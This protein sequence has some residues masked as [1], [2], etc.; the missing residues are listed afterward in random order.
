MSAPA[1]FRERS[2][3]AWLPGRADAGALGFCL[4]CAGPAILLLFP[5]ALP[6]LVPYAA[7]AALAVVFAIR[8]LQTGELVPRTFVDWPILLSLLVLPLG[9]WATA[10]RSV[11][12]PVIFRMVAGVAIFYGVAALGRTRWVHLLPWSAL[13]FAVVLAVTVLVGTRWAGYVKVP[14]FPRAW[15]GSLPGA[16]LPGGVGK[17]NANVG[18][19][20]LSLLVPLAAALTLWGRE[21]GLRLLALVAALA[22]AAVIFLTQA[23]VAWI[24]VPLALLIMPIP[25]YPRWGLILAAAAVLLIALVLG[26]G[27]SSIVTLLLPALGFSSP[28]V[29]GVDGRLAIWASAVALIGRFPLTGVGP[30]MFDR[31]A[32]LNV[33]D[34]EPGFNHAHNVFLQMALDFG[35]VGAVAHLALVVGLAAALIVALRRVSARAERGVLSSIGTGLLSS[36]LVYTGL[37]LL[38]GSSVS[39]YVHAISYAL[40]GMAAAFANYSSRPASEYELTESPAQ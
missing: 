30:G 36:L 31:V 34:L 18:A 25:R 10:D 22:C 26:F 28:T 17:I 13:A 15:Y 40:F 23:R 14:W 8:F 33:P 20:A 1:A 16:G 2:G 9:L 5:A 37:G 7:M 32:E 19:G 11:S 39:P 29:A 27:A 4:A 35:V 24:V 3:A 12:W 38:D 6:R 21:C